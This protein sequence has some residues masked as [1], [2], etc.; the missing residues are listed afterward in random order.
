M[1][2]SRIIVV[3]SQPTRK[4]YVRLAL[5]VG[6]SRFANGTDS[7]GGRSKFGGSIEY[8]IKIQA[9]QSSSG[10]STPKKVH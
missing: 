9:I 8:Q 4:L 3:P 2:V 7:V 6:Q 10:L 5:S 1:G